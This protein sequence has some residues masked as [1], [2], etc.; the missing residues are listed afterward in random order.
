MS[1]EEIKKAIINNEFTTEKGKNGE[2]YAYTLSGE[3]IQSADSENELREDF[4]E[5]KTPFSRFYELCCEKGQNLDNDSDKE[6][7]I[8]IDEN[9]K[10]Y[11]NTNV[12]IDENNKVEQ[13]AKTL[14]KRKNK[15]TK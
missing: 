15:L 2:I 10:E 12:Y 1:N 7:Y 3:F 9:N 4:E 5:I 11:V 6:F 14:V 8:E 13:K